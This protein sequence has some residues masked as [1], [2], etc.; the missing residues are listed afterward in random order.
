MNR[1]RERSPSP[2]KDKNEKSEEQEF[3]PSSPTA[4]Q[5]FSPS[6]TPRDDENSNSSSQVMENFDKEESHPKFNPD[7]LSMKPPSKGESANPR[8]KSSRNLRDDDMLQSLR[9][10][11]NKTILPELRTLHKRAV[12]PNLKGWRQY[13][14][15]HNCDRDAD[16]SKCMVFCLHCFGAGCS[17]CDGHLCEV[18]NNLLF[19]SRVKSVYSHRRTRKNYDLVTSCLMLKRML[20]VLRE[21]LE[22]A[23]RRG[24]DRRNVGRSKSRARSRSRAPERGRSRVRS[25][26]PSPRPSSPPPTKK[27]RLEEMAEEEDPGTALDRILAK[28]RKGWKWSSFKN[29]NK[30]SENTKSLQDARILQTTHAV[31]KSFSDDVY[32]VHLLLILRDQGK[33]KTAAAGSSSK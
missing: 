20:V 21:R 1:S 19:D 29:W 11:I 8:Y 23:S 14:Q 6:Y 24:R 7:S 28:K 15:D 10:E 18:H 12:S 22:E 17:N 16:A 25:R 32:D 27:P 3:R 13:Q 2:K 9:E 33:G 30:N 31:Q 5:G 26:S 4:E